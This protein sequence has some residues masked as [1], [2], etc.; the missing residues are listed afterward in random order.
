VRNRT[1]AALARF[2]A[3]C[4]L[5]A[6]P[7]LA[8]AQ[9]RCSNVD[10][11]TLIRRVSFEGNST[12]TDAELALHVVSTP[13][14]LT[15]RF[16]DNRVIPI[17]A[18]LGAGVGAATGSGTAGKVKGAS[19]GAVIGGALGLGVSRLTGTPRCLRPGT[20][21]GDIL[22][23]SGFYRDEGFR[24]VRVDTTTVVDGRWVD[25]L[26]KVIEGQPILVDTMAIIGFDTT[27]M[28]QVPKTLNSQKGG[29]YSPTLTQ[30]D[31][32]TLETQL[33]DNGYPEGR[34]DRD[35]KYLSTYRTSVEY[36]VTP[37][38]RARIGK[39]VIEQSGLQG[40]PNSI[41]EDVVRSILRFGTG[42]LYS[43]R[44]LFETERRYYRVG[45]FVSAE[46][47][48]DVSHVQADSLV[49]V[50]VI[51]VEDLMHSGSVE[52]A[53]GTLDCLRLR[54]NYSDKAFL[55]GVNRLDVTGSVSK[56]GLAQPTRWNGLNDAC[57]TA[58]RWLN[59]TLD[60]NEISSRQVNYNG[61]VRFSRPI[62]LPGGL[63]PS[64]SAYTERRG[65]YQA[66]LRTTLIG[67]AVTVSKTITR[68]IAFE[69]SY[70]LEFGHTDAAETVLCFLF[71]A[72]DASSREQLTNGDK[73]LAVLGAR[74][75]RDRRNNSDSASAGTLVRLDLRSS[76]RLLLSDPS[77]EFRKGVVDA[78]WYH[79][80][81]SG[82]VAVRAR[83]GLVGGG[84]QTNGALLPP[85]Q[86]RLYVGG[87]T[88][89]RGFRQNELGPVI[90]VTSNDTAQAQA[91]LD[92]PDKDSRTA[93]LQKLDVRI[94]PAGG[95]SMYVGN[96]EYRLP[97]PFLN[98]LQTV[99]FVDAGALSTRGITTLTGS[100]QFRYTPG[101]A[102]KHFSPVGPVQINIGY[103]RYDLLAGPAFSDQYRN[104]SG[105]P[106]LTCISGTVGGV[107]QPLSAISSQPRW[108]LRRL[109]L[110]VAFPPDF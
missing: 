52:P 22:N 41:H 60:T 110:S 81:G 89:V 53:L 20:L 102:V 9:L 37:G 54:G 14:D 95:N 35:V 91:V 75:S 28:G 44:L 67:G 108:S 98:T 101:I 34:V 19:L 58:A 12:F 33:H 24:D 96:L 56:V 104:S 38:P 109:T 62:P 30:E 74:F 65:G 99:L 29:R 94:I 73:R 11:D 76:N 68:T 45:S 97:G 26:F 5:L 4:G 86:E 40:R 105:Q 84:Q 25:V 83:A 70:N 31:I 64:L 8:E 82:V 23:L 36:H 57:V 51:L 10:V 66:Y 15:R 42:D 77:L 103:N 78:A 39:I 63:L 3:I 2:A 71:R 88:S 69:G 47:A 13:T 21:S 106:V 59:A 6:A 107:C 72:C 80:L 92:A 90:Y 43:E 7:A 18:I 50:R 49:D 93:A 55:G 48:P 85:P 17:G 79:R 87:E 100:N 16:I 32:D 46:V 1:T 27:T 61:T